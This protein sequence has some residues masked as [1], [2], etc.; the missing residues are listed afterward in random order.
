MANRNKVKLKTHLK[1]R[2]TTVNQKRV[3]GNN[4][5]GIIAIF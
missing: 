1:Q 2:D 3:K 5:I 4:I